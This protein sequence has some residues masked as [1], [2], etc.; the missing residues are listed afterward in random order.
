MELKRILRSKVLLFLFIITLI[1]TLSLFIAPM[2]VPPDTVTGL[3]GYSNRIDYTD[4]WDEMSL[5]PKLI[6][7][8]GDVQCHQ[9][10]YRTFYI[11]GNQMPVCARDVAI[12]IGLSIGL[13]AA[14]LI[15]Y[16]TS[17]TKTFLNLFPL[18]FRNFV[19][20]RIGRKLFFFLFIALMFLPLIID[21]SAQLLT[22]YEGSNLMRVLTGLPTGFA[23]GYLIGVLIGT[24]SKL[25]K[26][27]RL[28]MEKSA[29]Q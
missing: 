26:E 5:Y 19:K 24:I 3:D 15:S 27:E 28:L 9:K 10:S 29:T 25:R 14:M 21:G 2:T 4:R 17:P 11:N 18:R 12:Y 7:Y 23:G 1:W 20:K 8:L 16:T 22:S 6:Y 13:F